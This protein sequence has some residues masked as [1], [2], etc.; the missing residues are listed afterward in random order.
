MSQS[1]TNNSFKEL[2][3][4][5]SNNLLKKPLTDTL[6]SISN[7]ASFHSNS[8]SSSL[9]TSA[10]S[11]KNESQENKYKSTSSN[12]SN[13]T[14]SSISSTHTYSAGSGASNGAASNYGFT[15]ENT[16]DTKPQKYK[17]EQLD[18]LSTVGTGTFG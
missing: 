5:A 4:T 8:S 18:F 16:N 7:M 17:I 2:I 13:Q 1:N 3:S 15:D 14:Q 6:N 10:T 9:P 12:N 11:N